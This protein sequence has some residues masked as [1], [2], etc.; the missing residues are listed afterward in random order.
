MAISG[1]ASECQLQ[2]KP[3]DE[4]LSI[5]GPEI[6]VRGHNFVIGGNFVESRN[7]ITQFAISSQVV[8]T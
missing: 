1:G 4:A 3:T 2:S 8:I 5:K 6:I 7:F